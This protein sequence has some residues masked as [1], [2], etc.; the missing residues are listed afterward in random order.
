MA[1]QWTK[2]LFIFK[3][4]STL[5]PMVSILTKMLQAILK[6]LIVYGLFLWIF[7]SGGRLF[8]TNQES[9]KDQTTTIMTLF[10]ASL[11]SFSFNMWDDNVQVATRYN[12]AFLI[13]FLIISNVIL[14]N[15]I[16]A[17][18]S[19]I[20]DAVKSRSNLIHLAD[21]IKTRCVF[22]YN[23]YYSSMISSFIPFN[24]LLMPTFPFLIL[25]KSRKLN[26]ILMHIC[27]V[28]VLIIGTTLFLFI[29]FW[30]VPFAYIALIYQNARFSLATN[31]S[32]A[33]R[34]HEISYFLICLV[35]DLP[36]LIIITIGNT[37]HFVKS[38]YYTDLKQVE[39]NKFNRLSDLRDLDKNTFDLFRKKLGKYK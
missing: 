4:N 27:F 22:G 13:A 25:C 37:I 9:F 16:I 2:V 28:P 8:Y 20:Y 33:E 15:F 36:L 26:T 24:M 30:M 10:T 1:I 39:E 5:G 35:K 21:I 7:A 34:R 11:G 12:Y 31:L 17:I 6:F 18:L 23:E 38:L 32:F 14:L 29:S 19:T 3:V